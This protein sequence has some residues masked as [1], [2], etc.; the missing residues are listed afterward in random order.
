ML[1]LIGH[2]SFVNSAAFSPDGK[3]IVSGSDDHTVRVWDAQTGQQILSFP[4]HIKRVNTVAFSPNGKRIVSGGDDKEVKVWN[5]Q[6]GQEL[7]SFPGHKWDVR[8]VAFSPDGKRI[9]S[10]GEGDGFCLGLFTRGEVRVWDAETGQESL[11]L[12][13]HKGTV[14]SVAFSPDGKRIV[15]GGEDRTVRLWDAQTGVETLTLEGHLAAVTSVAFSPDGQRIASACCRQL[16]VWDGGTRA[17][18]PD[19]LGERPSP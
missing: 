9:A 6:T 2:I 16:K 13:G 1:T 10:G 14:R 19:W 11:L 12:L 4:G 8:A 5:A 3:R 15:S 17:F 18:F 7:L